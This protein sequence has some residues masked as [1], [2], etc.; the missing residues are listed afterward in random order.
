[1]IGKKKNTKPTLIALET[2]LYKPVSK[3]H[4]S[5]ILPN[6]S[7]PKYKDHAIIDGQGNILNFC[8]EKYQLVPNENV[9]PGI[10]KA[11]KDRKLQFEKKITI[12]DRTQ[13]FVDYI[14]H[15]NTA[16]KVGDVFPKLSVWNSYDGIMKFRKEFGFWRTV[17]S[18]GLSKPIG[19]ITKVIEKHLSGLT[20]GSYED[21]EIEHQAIGAQTLKFIQNISKD[22]TVFKK[23]DSIKATENTLTKLA[24]KAHLS[25]PITRAALARFMQEKN[26][27]YT[28]ENIAGDI[29]QA[30]GA[31]ATVWL[32]YNA[33]NWA[34]FNGNS[35]EGQDTKL[36]KDQELLKFAI[37]LI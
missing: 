33:L 19:D 29:L 27:G 22:F 21:F 23:L 37:E 36:K 8:S 16:R 11:L 26:G 25:G 4:L 3:V 20:P 15:D 18:N 13:F 2:E 32:A 9:F 14:I 10:E 24:K 5:E 30:D 6:K 12:T 7:F 35:K 1:M 17:C 28:Y 34:V 31:D